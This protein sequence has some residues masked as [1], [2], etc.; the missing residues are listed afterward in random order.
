MVFTGKEIQ[1][2]KRFQFIWNQTTKDIETRYIPRTVKPT[3]DL[4]R[5]IVEGTCDTVPFV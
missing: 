5:S 1:T 3:L 2:E 4:K